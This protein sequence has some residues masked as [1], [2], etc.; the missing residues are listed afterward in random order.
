MK[1]NQLERAVLVAGTAV[2]LLATADGI[3][4]SWICA[5]GGR[6]S[7]FDRAST[8][9]GTMSAEAADSASRRPSGDVPDLLG[10]CRWDGHARDEPSNSSR[11]SMPPAPASQRGIPCPVQVSGYVAKTASRLDVAAEQEASDSER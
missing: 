6:G 7:C 8:N 3:R 1:L 10:L 9:E 2:F 11:T 4:M 5:A